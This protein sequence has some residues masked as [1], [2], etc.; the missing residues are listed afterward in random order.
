M[1][2][3]TLFWQAAE[4]VKV[5]VSGSPDT[6]TKGVEIA[7][8]ANAGAAAASAATARAHLALPEAGRRVVRNKFFF[9]FTAL[10]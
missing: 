10:T 1:T 2:Q 7:P 5:S 4:Q 3:M 9:A 6:L 8:G